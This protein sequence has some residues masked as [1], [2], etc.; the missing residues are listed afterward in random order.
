MKTIEIKAKNTESLFNILKNEIGGSLNIKLKEY[1]L[2]FNND[3]GKGMVRGMKVA[4]NITFLQFD[5]TFNENIS[6]SIES[7]QSAVINFLYCNEGKLSHAFG[8]NQSKSTLETFQT[9]ISANI[10]TNKNNIYFYKDNKINS[11]L[12][13]VNTLLSNQKECNI[14][15]MLFDTFIKEKVEDQLYVGSYN[16]KITDYI[17]QLDAVK[18]EGVVR[19]L[20]IEGLVNLILASE[21]DQH[22]K[23]SEK[24]KIETGSLT[25]SEMKEIRDLSEYIQNYPE[26]NMSVDEWCAKIGLSPAK[27]QEGFKLIHG[28]TINEFIRYVR[29]KKSEELIKTTDLNISEIVYTLGLS[30]RSYFSHIFKDMYNCSP[31]EYKK[32]N[33]LAATA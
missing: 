4:N 5:A 11:V 17:K 30:S 1:E 19:M 9:G 6:L 26:T 7:P 15:T 25:V 12:I 33:R 14:N 31:S 22:K 28:K 29:V 27:V 16:L 21:V 10:N 18:Q 23:D 13:S 8:P 3:L 2:V 20:L 24:S 32:K